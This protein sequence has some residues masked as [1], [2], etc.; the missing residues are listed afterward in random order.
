MHNSQFPEKTT[1][2]VASYD[3]HSSSK[4]ILPAATFSPRVT[5]RQFNYFDEAC[6][7]ST[8]TPA[9]KYDPV[10][11]N[12]YKKKTPVALIK[13]KGSSPRF[14]KLVLNTTSG[15]GSYD[16]A[17]SFSK[18]HLSKSNTKMGKSS[19]ECFTSVIAKTKISPGPAKHSPTIA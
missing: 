7:D 1:P 11:L 4:K 9:A 2:G 8:K 6:F 15:P 16:I 14:P 3:I 10:N 13:R 12:L 19:K 17:E 5:D 18:T